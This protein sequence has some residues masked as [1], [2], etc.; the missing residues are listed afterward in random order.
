MFGVCVCVCVCV[1]VTA[2]SC[3][4]CGALHRFPAGG[5]HLWVV[6]RVHHPRHDR[7]HCCMKSRGRETTRLGTVGAGPDGLLDGSGLDLLRLLERQR[8]GTDWF[9]YTL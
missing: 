4:S 8:R 7:L 2:T 6:W 3:S 9:S 5:S 1:T